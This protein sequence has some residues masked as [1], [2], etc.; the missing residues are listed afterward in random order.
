MTD[1]QGPSSPQQAPHGAPAYGPPA[2]GAPVNGSPGYG[3][4]GRGYPGNAPQ[5]AGLYTSYPAPYTPPAPSTTPALSLTSMIIGLA[6]IF[7]GSIVLLPIGAIVLGIIG[8]R[9]ERNGRGL[10][11]TGIIAG[12]VTLLFWIALVIVIV[13]LIAVAAPSGGSGGIGDGGSQALY[14]G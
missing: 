7:F 12:G 2:Y 11:I 3:L 9:R 4:P 1:N 5:A 14:L 13:V 6:S 10:A 8:L